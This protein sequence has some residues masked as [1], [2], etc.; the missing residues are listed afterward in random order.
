MKNISRRSFVEMAGVAA[1]GLGLA[2]CGG[3]SSSSADTS[4]AEYEPV[5]L[6]VAFMPNLGS[7]STLYSGI[8]QGYFEEYG[9]TVEPQRFTGGPAEIAAMQSGDIDISQIGH[10]AH[11][12]C[13]QG[14]ASVLALDQLG[15]ADAVL[16]LKSH[17][18]ESAADL[19]G[20][21]VAVASG[22]SSEIILQFVL[23]DG[24]LT[25]DDIEK[26]EMDVN[27][28]TTAMIAG[29]VDAAACW[30]PNTITIRTE[31]GEDCI[32]LGTNKDYNDKVA[33]P[34]SYICLPDFATENEDV[35][36]RF[37]QAILKSQQY[38]S[39]HIEDVAKL[40]ATEL[41]LDEETLLQSVNEGNW[42]TCVDVRGNIDEIKSYYEAQQRV[43][44]DNGTIEAEV[45]VENYVL[46]DLMKKYTEEY[47]KNA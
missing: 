10:G 2:A 37:G 44:L 9:I 41:E 20:K 11:S 14:Q 40:L 36:V 12:L 4:A 5:T 46:L 13:I 34:A 3:S 8:S 24:G 43:F 26:V 45:P 27:G 16:A 18:I 23:A 35:L 1:A 6:R 32:T 19:K 39:E 17:G 47:E 29:Q 21:T 33:F 15:E 30:S 7:A 22:T 31:L 25:V 42:Q 28:M 38:R